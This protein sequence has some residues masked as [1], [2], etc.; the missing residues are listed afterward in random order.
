VVVQSDYA[1]VVEGYGGLNILDISDPSNPQFVGLYSDNLEYKSVAI[2][3]HYAYLTSG[4]DLVVV[5][6]QDPA[7]PSFVVDD[8]W[9][10]NA[11]NRVMIDGNYAYLVGEQGLWVLDVTNPAVPILAL[12]WES[13]S[14]N[15]IVDAVWHNNHLILTETAALYVVKGVDPYH[16]R[17]ANMAALPTGG[18]AY[19]SMAVGDTLY[20]ADGANGLLVYDISQPWNNLPEL[21][22]AYVPANPATAVTALDTY[23]YIVDG[24]RVQVVNAA[25]PSA[26]TPAGSY[27]PAP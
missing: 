17:Q 21:G 20:V 24:A 14:G 22:P 3:G 16:L 23:A 8:Y 26:L 12:H 15:P 7:K 13:G 4:T 25:Q 19:R 18:T 1:Y 5:D 27:T 9:S 6:I 10:G 11:A 2:S